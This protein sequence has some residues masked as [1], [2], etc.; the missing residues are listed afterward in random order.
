MVFLEEIL[1]LP[2]LLI[3]PCSKGYRV[4]TYLVIIV[5]I[6]IVGFFFFFFNLY[7]NQR[8]PE[9]VGLGP[10]LLK[11]FSVSRRAGN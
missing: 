7:F 2:L 5:M 8:L 1:P 10:Q 4:Q 3:N 6:V 11:R 9:P